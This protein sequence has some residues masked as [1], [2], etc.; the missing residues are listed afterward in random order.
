VKALETR[1]YSRKFDAICALAKYLIDEAVAALEKALSTTGLSRHLQ[2]HHVSD[3][4]NMREKC[5]Y[6]RIQ[7]A[8]DE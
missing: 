2:L 8:Q 4:G 1:S 7:R 5:A 6:R 3:R